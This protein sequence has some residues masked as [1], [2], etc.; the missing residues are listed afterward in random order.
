MLLSAYSAPLDSKTP[1]SASF[2]HLALDGMKNSDISNVID[3]HLQADQIR[4][5]QTKEIAEPGFR[6]LESVH[7]R[8]SCCSI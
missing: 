5:R 7:T 4:H 8:S 3:T 2:N 1:R 6:C